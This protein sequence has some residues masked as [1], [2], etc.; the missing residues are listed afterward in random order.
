[1]QTFHWKKQ[2]KLQTIRL[3]IFTEFK[4][5]TGETVQQYM[6]RKKKGKVL[7]I[8]PCTGISVLRKFILNRVLPIIRFLIK[9]LKNIT[10]YLLPDSVNLHLK[11]FRLRIIILTLK[12]ILKEK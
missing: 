3:F 1:M 11:H 2:H 6:L 5:I 12:S 4:L 7:F 9:R 8:V 10:E